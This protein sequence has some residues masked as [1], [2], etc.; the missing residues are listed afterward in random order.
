MPTV[1]IVIPTYNEVEN[2]AELIKQIFD[3]GIENISIVVVDDNSPDGTSQAVA[4][5]QDIYPDRLMVYTRSGKLGIG[6]A[7]VYGFMYAIEHGYEYVFEMDADFSHDPKHIPELLRLATEGY[8]LVIGSRRVAGGAIEGWGYKR[9]LMSRMAMDFSRLLLGL[10]TQDVTT[11]YRCY[12]T[13]TLARLDVSKITSNGYSFQEEMIYWFE[14]MNSRII[15]VPITFVDR[16][17]GKSKLSVYEI[18]K[19]FITIFRIKFRSI[20][21]R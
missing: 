6:S 8:D 3:L 7:Y 9:M 2:I 16:R 15:E 20:P 12:K 18:I 13:A 1:L 19:F 10:T 11:G 4:G 17:F 5:L 21:Y 14:Q